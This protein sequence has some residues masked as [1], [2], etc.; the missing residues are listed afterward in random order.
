M[1]PNKM[2]LRRNRKPER[3]WDWINNPKPA[4]M[5]SS[6]THG[7]MNEFYHSFKEELI[8]IL[9]LFQKTG[10]GILPNLFCRP[11]LLSYQSLQRH[12]KTEASSIP[13]EHKCKNI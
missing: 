1:Q 9:K 11:A 8:P 4:N 3:K 12:K 10:E 2:K 5:E 7:F 6:R 13:D